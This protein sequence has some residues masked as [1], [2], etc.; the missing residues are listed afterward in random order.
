MQLSDREWKKFKVKDIF[1]VEKCK[2]SNVS[3]LGVGNFPYVGATNRNNGIMC[4]VE[5]KEK[6]ITKGNCIVFICDGQGSVGYSMY[7]AEDFIGSTTLK[8]GRNTHMNKQSAQFLVSALDKNRSIYSYGYKRNTNRLSNETIILPIDENGNPDYDFMEAYI[9]EQEVRKKHLYINY[10]KKRVSKFKNKKIC[11]L[12]EKEWAT[13]NIDDIF[14]ISSGKRFVSE[15]MHPG[16]RPFIGATD[17]GNGI[18]NFVSDTNES[19]DKN[20]LGVN[21]NGNGMVISFYHPYECLFTDDVKRFHLKDYEDNKFVLLFLKTVILQQKEKYNYGYKFNRTR[22]AR[23]KILLPID[24]KG[25]PD[26][27]YMEQYSKNMMLRKYQQYLDYISK[28]T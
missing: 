17:S 2:C 9:R 5:K 24:E 27:E 26:Y 12:T 13:F 11:N 7:K 25:K 22:M 16:T 8:A 21:Y 18:T 4:F 10:V 6:W 23:Q 1:I 3:S 15:H 28:Q 19:V 14:N 20:V